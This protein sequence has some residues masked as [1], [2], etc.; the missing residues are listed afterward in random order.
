MIRPPTVQ[1]SSKLITLAEATGIFKP[2][3]VETLLGRVLIEFYS[4]SLKQGHQIGV[5]DDGH[6]CALGWTYFAP[7]L[8]V[9]KIWDLLW[10]GVDPSQHNKGIGQKLLD[11]V[12]SEVFTVGGR[13]LVIETSSTARFEKVRHFYSSRGYTKCGSVPG[14]YGANDDK[15]TFVKKM[16]AKFS[17][18]QPV[19]DPHTFDKTKS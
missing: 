18:G 10:I 16:M 15:V 3:E 14:F 11:F 1:E 9:E 13:L 12:E 8:K 5:F 6:G 19:S 17:L 2:T 7:S 4:G